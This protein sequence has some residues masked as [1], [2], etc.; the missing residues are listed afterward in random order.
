VD[1]QTTRNR[2]VWGGLLVL[3]G[4][5]SLLESTIGLSSWVWVICLV[6]A[7]TVVM[8]IYARDRGNRAAMIPSYVLWA[9]ALLIALTSL[10]VL[11][12]TFIATFVLSGVALPFL[13]VYMKDR[14]QWWAL[15]PA[16]VLLA[17]ALMVALIGIRLLRNEAIATYVL[18]A[19]ALPFLTVYMRNRKQWWALIPTYVLGSLGLMVGL[20][21]VGLLRNFLIPAYIMY[22]IAAPFFVV[23]ARDQKQWWALIPAGIMTAL[24]SAFLIASAANS[25]FVPAILIFAGIWLVASQ[26]IGRKAKQDEAEPV[27]VE[28]EEVVAEPHEFKAP[29]S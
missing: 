27:E 10:R 26:F 20:I 25:M 9:I 3:L 2:M 19:I 13:V 18:W 22:A 21:G 11:R 14:K 1:S 7:G 17:V 4:I 29:S 12:G 8:L 23:Y 28:P 6:A 16:Y 5:L 24:G 15:I